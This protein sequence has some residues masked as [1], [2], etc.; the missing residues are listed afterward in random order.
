MTAATA[1]WSALR[2]GTV[3]IGWRTEILKT[4]SEPNKFGDHWTV[5]LSACKEKKLK[6][7]L[8]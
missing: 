1:A 3:A 4:F 7:E 2:D 5:L 8:A 6:Q